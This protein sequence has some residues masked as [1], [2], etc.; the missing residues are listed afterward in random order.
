MKL[1]RVLKGISLAFLVL[2]TGCSTIQSQTDGSQAKPYLGTSKAIS[3]AKHVWHHY[4]YFGQFGLYAMD[5]PAC[6]VADTLLLP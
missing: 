1:K 5:V 4:D 3:K 6:L 2:L